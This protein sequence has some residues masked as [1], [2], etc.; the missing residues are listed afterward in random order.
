MVSSLGAKRRSGEVW[1]AGDGKI[2]SAR[3][4]RRIPVGERWC[5]D[6]VAWVTRVPWNR[7]KDAPGADGDLPEDL[8]VEAR[9]L[10]GE[11]R[12]PI[13]VSTREKAPMGFY[14][15]KE[16]AEKHGY[17]R[18]CGGC[19]SWFRGLGRQPHNE[20]CRERF[21][22]MMK[23]DAKVKNADERKVDSGGKE[24]E[25]NIKKSGKAAKQ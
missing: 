22:D 4:V 1:L 17:T 18:G 10:P 9:P 19:S 20:R 8:V 15:K 3:S 21:W 2:F 16:D 25:E 23:E 14:I 5:E 13:I 11:V 24:M 12:N 6:C 7:Y